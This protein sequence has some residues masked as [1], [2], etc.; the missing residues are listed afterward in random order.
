[1]RMRKSEDDVSVCIELRHDHDSCS[2]RLDALGSALT[3][4]SF[5]ASKRAAYTAQTYANL[6]GWRTLEGL[7]NAILSCI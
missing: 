2:V 1:M 5:T 3:R 7:F 6:P 4:E